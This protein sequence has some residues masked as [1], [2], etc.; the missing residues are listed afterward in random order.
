MI[1]RRLRGEICIIQAVN[2]TAQNSGIYMW[3]RQNRIGTENDGRMT[4]SGRGKHLKGLW[5]TFLFV[6]LV[7]ACGAGTAFSA[8]KKPKVIN[9]GCAGGGGAGKPFSTGNIGTVQIRGMLEEEFRNEG[10][11]INWYFFKGSGPAANE[12]IANGIIDFANLGDFPSIVGKAGGLKT[13]Y[14][15]G[16]PLGDVNI[17]IPSDSNIVSIKGLKG[18]RIGMMKGTATQPVLIRILES[19]GLSERDVRIFDSLDIDAALASRDIDAGITGLRARDLGIAKVLYSTNPQIRA[20]VPTGKF[21]EG[22]RST[23]G[24]VVTEKFANDYP[25]VTRRVVKVYF[26]AARWGAEE[27]NRNELLRLWS[28][29]GTPFSILKEQYKPYNGKAL[30]RLVIDEFCINHHKEVLDFARKRGLVNN[31]FDVDKWV[32]TSYQ[33]L[34][35]KEL[36]LE[37]FW[38]RYDANGKKSK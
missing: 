31:T 6:L 2:N 9:I 37:D 12:S 19:H 15:A 28:Q 21:P 5:G 36:G 23:N 20:I 34:A 18:K 7:A 8:E 14:I 24:L 4:I 35:L 38:P 29:S 33:E 25:E 32:D 10:I 17:L 22:W 13:K 1:P 30:S 11:K 27:K 26:Q 16:G 3:Q